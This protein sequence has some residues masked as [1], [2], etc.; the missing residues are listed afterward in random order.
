MQVN[1]CV[2]FWITNPLIEQPANPYRLPQCFVA[3]LAA[4]GLWLGWR[5]SPPNQQDFADSAVHWKPPKRLRSLDMPWFL[6]NIHRKTQKLHDCCCCSRL[7]NC[8]S[9]S[10]YKFTTCTV[11][12]LLGSLFVEID[13]FFFKNWLKIFHSRHALSV[14]SHAHT[15]LF[16]FVTAKNSVV[17]ARFTE[18]NRQINRIFSYSRPLFQ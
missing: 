15:L 11:L 10:Y 12:L 17:F 13:F 2:L 3:T 14:H 1:K 7:C 8:R 16:A 5:C 6:P 9:I 18:F 4:F